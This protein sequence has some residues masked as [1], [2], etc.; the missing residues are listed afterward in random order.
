MSVHPNAKNLTAD[1]VRR[2]SKRQPRAPKPNRDG[3]PDSAK[4]VISARSMGSC[5]LDFCGPAQHYHHRAPRQRG[6]TR[7]VWV[8]SPANGLHLAP[9]CH[10]R[11]EARRTEAY[12]NGWLV[13][14]NGAKPAAVVPVLYRGRWVL[15]DDTGGIRPIGGDA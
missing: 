6:G 8:N 10:D 15:L 2:L 14:R 7:L 5:E 4:R 9:R 3:F 1:M 13:R 11:I 12:V